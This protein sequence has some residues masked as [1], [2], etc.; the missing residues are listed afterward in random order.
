MMPN[1]T[2]GEHP[3]TVGSRRHMGFSL[4]ELLVVVTV[5]LTLTSIVAATFRM[6]PSRRVENTAYV[7][8]AHLELARSHA[9]GNRRL[10]RVNFDIPSETYTAYADHDDNGTLTG[11]AAEI[12]AF[13][14]FGVRELDDQV[15]FGRGV[16]TALPGD[17]AVGPITLA[18]GH[19]TFDKQGIPTPMGSMGTIYLTHARDP[20][21]VAAISV[22]SSGSFKAWRWAA[23]LGAW[24]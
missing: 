16:A 21:A 8:V 15:V 9:L 11:I 14:A 18:G 7:I 4:I 23:D 10:V 19:L 5:L 1:G 6:S 2:A 12:E 3:Q 24:R 22:A 20:S 13:S 17:T